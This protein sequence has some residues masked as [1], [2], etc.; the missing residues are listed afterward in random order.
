MKT[1]PSQNCPQCGAL[2]ASNAPAGL[3]P[4]CL[5]AL[6]LK[7]ETVFT[8]AAAQPVAPLPPEAIAPHFPQLEILECLGRGGMGVVYRARQKTLNRLVALKLLAPERVGDPKFADRFAREAQALA[9]LNHPNIVTVYD[10]GQA[11]GFYFLLMEFVDGV[12][13]RQLLRARKF[14][15]E[16]ALAIVPPLCEALQFAHDRGIVHRDIKPENLLLDKSGRVKIADFG[17]AKILGSGDNGGI[18]GGAAPDSLTQSTV[19]TPGYSA[20]EQKTDPQSVDNRA[21]IY[22][23]GVVIYEMLTG[24]LPGKPLEP[25]S[26]KVRVDVRIDEIVLRALEKE[27]ELRFQTAAQMRTE[28]ETMMGKPAVLAA[29]SG[30]PAAG[31]SWQSPP[32]GWGHFIGYLAGI[33]FTSR[34]AFQLANVSALGFLGALAFLGFVPLPGMHWC[35]GFAGFTGFFGLIG[36]A[37][38]VEYAARRKSNTALAGAAMVVLGL[39]AL[40]LAGA[41]LFLIFFPQTVRR[42]AT[43]PNPTAAGPARNASPGQAVLDGQYQ[44]IAVTRGELTRI[45]AAI[46]TLAP[47]TD[48]PS[49]WRISAAVSEAVI[50]LVEAGQDVEFTVDAFPDRI[51]KGRVSEVGNEP[52]KQDNSVCYRAMIEVISPEPK[53]KPGM[54]ATLS[55]I[56]AHRAAAL[57]IPVQALGFRPAGSSPGESR[58]VDDQGRVIRTVYIFRGDN[59]TTIE[60]VQIRTGI[61]DDSHIE[62]LDGLKEGDR[63]ILG[64]AQPEPNAR[65]IEPV[66]PVEA[67]EPAAAD[68]AGVPAEKRFAGGDTNKLYFLIGR[69]NHAAMVNAGHRLLLVLPGGDG[70]PD[71]QPFVKRIYQNA[72]PDGY[73]V[74]QLIAPKWDARQFEQIVWPTEKSRYPAMKFSTEVFVNSVVADIE[75][76]HGLDTNRIFTLAWSSGGP[77]AYA[78]SLDPQTRVTGSFIAMSVFNSGQLPPLAAARGRAYFLLHSPTDFIPMSMPEQAREALGS[79]GAQVRLQT[80]EGGHGWHGDVLGN[81]RAGV[82]WLEKSDRTD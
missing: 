11:A 70:G 52:I 8:N 35:F 60:P 38:L 10:F 79:N 54:T 22:S 69:T 40:F 51:L 21:D 43:G 68:V 74:A 13:L 16:E 80:Y 32:M 53:F 65:T 3:C 5:L 45:I 25:P 18:P 72:L 17:I 57:K 71:F 42:F 49:R 47:M 15:P 78:L 27:P 56:T 64:V 19:G 9:A 23:L 20:P 76:R 33:T 50:A 44:T 31:K 77:A 67:P 81:I 7:T 73:L 24:E 37:H 46:G 39:M 36:A 26:K 55:F 6:N 41:A 4:R 62:V 30:A 12:N 63:V 14:T 48:G 2:V 28:V 82:E 61:G 75:S 66:T 58:Q 59:P 34:V 1:N 29:S